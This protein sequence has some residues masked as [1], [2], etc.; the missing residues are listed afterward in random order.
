MVGH[1][2]STV[3]AKNLIS[4]SKVKEMAKAKRKAASKLACTMTFSRRNLFE[5]SSGFGRGE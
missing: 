2:S 5:I 4:L 1:T 3:F